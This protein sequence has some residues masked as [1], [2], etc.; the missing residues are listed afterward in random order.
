M[1]SS[2]LE[3]AS[4]SRRPMIELLHIRELVEED[5]LEIS[6]NMVRQLLRDKEL[7]LR[8]FSA[9]PVLVDGIMRHRLENAD[10][11]GNSKLPLHR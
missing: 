1:H 9:Q 6:K 3:D 2:S 5:V 10:S 11:R 4:G 8:R 7:T